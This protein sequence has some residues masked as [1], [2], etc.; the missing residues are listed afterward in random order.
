MLDNTLAIFE[1]AGAEIVDLSGILTTGMINSITSGIYTDT[2]EYDVNKYLYE[3]GDAAPYKTVSEM[4]A[5]N[6]GGTMHMYLS[7]LTAD[8]YSLAGSFETT[9]DPYTRTVGDYKRIM[10]WQK[11]LDGRA[12]VTQILEDNGID[13]VMYLSFF[14]TADT[15]DSYIEDD[16]NYAGYDI[17]FGPKLGLPEIS[18]P[19]GFSD[20]GMPLGL[21]LFS[22]FGQEQKLIDIA[23]AYEQQAGD[24]IRRIPDNIPPLADEGL[25]QY[26]AD[27]IE[28]AYELS[29]S[30]YDPAFRGLVQEMLAAC[31]K[32]S[33][34][35]PEDPY[36]MYE[37]AEEIAESYDRMKAIIGG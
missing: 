24:E 33:T 30:R 16:P 20:G 7:N 2:F 26:V 8:Y 37:V 27:M 25:N 1:G 10:D 22:G 11:A 19:M 29:E 35:D 14:D 18:L 5:Y 4:L 6:P 32:A 9:P 36:A 31:D 3:K 21:S 17:S 28:K 23:Y 15:D 34:V 13:A 12:Q